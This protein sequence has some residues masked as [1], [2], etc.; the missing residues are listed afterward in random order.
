MTYHLLFNS[1]NNVCEVGECVKIDS[2]FELDRSVDE[3]NYWL[4]PREHKLTNKKEYRHRFIVELN[5][6]FHTL[7]SLFFICV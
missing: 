3:M 1:S 7:E 6:T 5:I 4:I 2:V